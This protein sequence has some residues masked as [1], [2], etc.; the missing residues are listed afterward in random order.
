MTKSQTIWA[1]DR[2]QD[3]LENLQ[4][5]LPGSPAKSKLVEE[6]LEHYADDV[7]DH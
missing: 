2:S 6:A 3:L 5:C 4:D 7:L 1:T